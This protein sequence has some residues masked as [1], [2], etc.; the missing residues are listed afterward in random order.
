MSRAET[1]LW[2][3]DRIGVLG[4]TFD[5]PH[6]GHV[7][8]ALHALAV[9]GLDRVLFSVAPR[10]PH[11]TSERMTPLAH[12]VEMV[13]LA[14]EGRE[15][16]HLTQV[17]DEHEVSFTVE[18]LRACRARTRADLY[19]IAGGDSLADLHAWKDPAEILALATLVVFA[20]R[21][22]PLRVEVPGPAALVVFESPR[23]DVS[24]TEIRRLLARGGAPGDAVDPR[25]TAYAVRHA[26][27]RE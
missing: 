6:S 27:Y 17:E 10:P 22:G 2:R 3:G 18:L 20:R 7:G 1:E 24:S 21:P 14:I 19:F 13:R 16:L 25:V 8:M 26:L 9:L 12:R 4:G 11:K 5:P 15:G 23:F